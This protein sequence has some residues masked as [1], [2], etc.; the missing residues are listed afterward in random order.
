[1]TYI[2]QKRC[3]TLIELL[4]V[5]AIIAILAAILLPALKR[6]REA[7]LRAQCLSQHKQILLAATMYADDHDSLLPN[8]DGSWL[9][10]HKNGRYQ[11]QGIGQLVV[12]DYLPGSR[13]T[14]DLLFCPSANPTWNWRMPPH[15]YRELNDQLGS[16]N[17]AQSTICGKFCTFVGYNTETHPTQANLYLGRGEQSAEVLSPILTADLVYNGTAPLDNKRQG[18]EGKGVVAGFYDG[19]AKFQ[20]FTPVYPINWTAVYSNINPYGNFWHWA[21]A[22]YGQ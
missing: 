18:H 12:N 5:I 7:A 11:P 17:W 10:R 20:T 22:E 4:V 19:S 21:K 6:A 16:N 1:M 2:Y 3:F 8:T 9:S 14:I 13:E 15:M